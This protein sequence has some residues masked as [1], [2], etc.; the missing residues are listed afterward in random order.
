[1]CAVLELEDLGI[2][3]AQ[4]KVVRHFRGLLGKG[5]TMDYSLQ[6]V[7]DALLRERSARGAAPERK[8]SR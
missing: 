4:Q 3:G 6:K 2:D 7:M 5:R 8:A 1:M